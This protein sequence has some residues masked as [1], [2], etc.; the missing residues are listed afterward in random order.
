LSYFI[1]STLA[2]VLLTF[3]SLSYLFLFFALVLLFGIYFAWQIKDT[4]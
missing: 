4:K 3:F 2:V 1:G